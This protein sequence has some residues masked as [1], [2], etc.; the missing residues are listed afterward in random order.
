M[1]VLL[2][3]FFKKII[4][5]MQFNVLFDKDRTNCFERER[6]MRAPFKIK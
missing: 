4:K 2:N 5:Q 3:Q 6:G 1:L